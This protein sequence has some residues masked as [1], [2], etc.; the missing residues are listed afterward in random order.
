MGVQS[1]ANEKGSWWFPDTLERT[2]GTLS[3]EPTSGSE[4][5]LDKLILPQMWPPAFTWPVI[6]GELVDGTPITLLRPVM[7]GGKMTVDGSGTTADALLSSGLV[8]YGAHLASSDEFLIARASVCLDGLRQLCTTPAIVD[9]QL[10]RF[11]ASDGTGPAERIVAVPG[12]RMTFRLTSDDDVELELELDDGQRLEDFEERWLVQIQGLVI[13]AGNDPTVVKRVAVLDHDHGP[14]EVLMRLPG[15]AA[16]PRWKHERPLVPF[17]ALGDGAPAF[18]GGWFE[19]YENLGPAMLF[20]IA[21]LS[22]RMFLENR[23]LNDTS[24]AESYHRTLHDKPPITPDEHTEYMARMLETVENAD[25]RKHYEA[26]LR[27]AATQGQRQRLKWLIRRA[28]ATLPKLTVLK[29]GLADDLVDTRDAL[30]HL[31]P[32][33]PAGL[34]G[35]PLFRSIELLEVALQLN[36]LLDLGV[37]PGLAETLFDVCYYRRT[38]FID[39]P[40]E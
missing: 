10:V 27:F 8:L 33:G 13:L 6:L 7:Q 25:H 32:T 12:A 4:L 2:T 23:L 5:K 22:E 14:V 16:E 31:D 39:I 40:G 3:F 17:A 30:T 38:P 20:F 35:G 9:D 21:A 24:F 1:I 34:S 26:R 19:L 11:V 37:E 29:V 28:K 18:I 36:I 15:L